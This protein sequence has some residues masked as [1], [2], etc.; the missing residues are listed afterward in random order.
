MEIVWLNVW[1]I[2]LIQMEIII[3]GSSLFQGEEL[4]YLHIVKIMW[5]IMTSDN[6]LLQF[7]SLYKNAAWW[8]QQKMPWKINVLKQKTINTLTHNIDSLPSLAPACSVGCQILSF[9]LGCVGMRFCLL[10]CWGGT[11]AWGLIQQFTLDC[12]WMCC[13]DLFG[14]RCQPAGFGVLLPPC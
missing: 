1:N 2:L 6:H 7:F 9:L 13:H 3:P 4:L 8:M 11:L 5:L 12:L 14:E 10:N